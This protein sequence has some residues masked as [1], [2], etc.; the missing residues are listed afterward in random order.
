[1]NP[2]RIALLLLACLVAACTSAPPLPPDLPYQNLLMVVADFQRYADRDPYAYRPPDDMSGQNA[3]RATL[4]RLDNYAKTYPGR[5]ADIVE[6]TRARALARL[7]QFDPAAKAYAQAAESGSELADEAKAR[8]ERVE[9]LA[10]ASHRSPSADNL[11]AYLAD[12]ELRRDELARLEAQ[13]DKTVE[14]RLA[15]RERER[16]E[17]ELALTLFR[18]RYV[19]ADGAARGLDMMRD[20]IEFHAQSRLEVRHHL[21]FGHMQF[22]L[23]RDMTLLTPPEGATFDAALF[24][25]LTQGA[26]EQFRTVAGADGYEEKIEGAAMVDAL[27]G[28]VRRVHSELE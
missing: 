10:R 8:A 18:N 26:A 17:V 6:F 7:G 27:E 15:R 12:L 19:L 21:M 3:W 22:E 25:R 16:I 2:S 13:F 1:M 4:E 5:D 23:A 9:A 14:G 28:F 24:D 11:D 20:I